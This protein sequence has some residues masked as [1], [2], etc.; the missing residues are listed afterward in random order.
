MWSWMEEG[1]FA[2]QQSHEEWNINVKSYYI[3]G[4]IR[5]QTQDD[6]VIK[7]FK[8]MILLCRFRLFR[9]RQRKE[10]PL[11]SNLV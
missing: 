2:F 3:S 11:K 8:L 9:C 1:K 10:V 7:T 4:P 5:N 6:L